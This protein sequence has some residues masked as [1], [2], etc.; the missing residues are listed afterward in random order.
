[1][2]NVAL[3]GAG[4]IGQIRADVIKRSSH[5]RLVA[6]NDIDYGLAAGV[7]PGGLASTMEAILYGKHIDAVVIA[8]PTKFHSE[9]A[10]R[11]LEASKHVLCEKPMG[12][13]VTEARAMYFAAEAADR[14]LWAGF[15][16]REMAH[17]R[18]AK[19]FVDRGLLGKLHFFQ[20]RFG[21]GGR[22]HY[23][24]EWCTQ[25]ELSGGGVLIEQGIHIMDLVRHLFGEPYQVVAQT[26][27]LFHDFKDTED[28]AFCLLNTNR[29][30]VQIH[31]SWTR[32]ENIFEI[33]IFGSKGFLRLEGR[34]GH[35]GPQKVIF[36]ERQ[37]D[38]SRPHEQKF[39]FPIKPD[40]WTLDWKAF[41][42]AIKTNTTNMYSGIRAQELVAAAYS[43]AK[44]NAWVNL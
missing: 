17:V 41:E 30:L 24:E 26:D 2:L 1:M 27:C 31:V 6:V 32:W 10:I 21:H 4:R 20:C 12:R 15:N 7:E 44:S 38:H 8:T 37:T 5:A 34:D 25:K 19:D 22:P 29:G 39:D 36:G 14:V 40:S 23:K 33:E 3:I 35:Y 11:A 43:S 42:L 16:Y 18:F 13:N 28:N 9:I